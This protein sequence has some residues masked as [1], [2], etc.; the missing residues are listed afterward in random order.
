MRAVLFLTAFGKMSVCVGW[1]VI[2]IYYFGDE[3]I[4]GR[5]IDESI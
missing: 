2:I 5:E 4:T 1:V 3:M